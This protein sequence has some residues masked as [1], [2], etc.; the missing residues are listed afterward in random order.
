MGPELSLFDNDVK[1]HSLSPAV[2]FFCFYKIF[3]L[4]VKK[5]PLKLVQ[6]SSKSPVRPD[7]PKI[8]SKG[9]GPISKWVPFHWALGTCGIFMKLKQLIKTVFGLTI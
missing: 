2:S 6:F 3:L 7:S 9:S 5:F 8:L 4:W 1:M